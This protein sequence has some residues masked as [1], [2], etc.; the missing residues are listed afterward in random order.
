M[1]LGTSSTGLATQVQRPGRFTLRIPDDL[2]FE[3]AATMPSVYVT[4]LLG[5]VQKA[6]LEKG[7]SVLIHAAAG[8][9]GIAAIQVA[10][11]IGA[12]IYCTVGNEEKA[13]FLVNKFG[14]PRGPHLPL[15]RHHLLRR[16]YGSYQRRWR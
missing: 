4:V 12:D 5:L 11:W 2:S 10:R 3:D 1:I 7:Q 8:G 16:A 6:Q 9:I 15:A 13:D 14:I